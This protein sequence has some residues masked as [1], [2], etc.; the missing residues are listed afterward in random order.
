MAPPCVNDSDNDCA[1]TALTD[2]DSDSD[3]DSDDGCA[4]LALT[5]SDSDSDSDAD[6]D[7][8]ATAQHACH[9]QGVALIFVPSEVWMHTQLSQQALALRRAVM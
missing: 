8:C 3:D 9:A 4:L 7:L 2:S 6:A 1:S 5:D